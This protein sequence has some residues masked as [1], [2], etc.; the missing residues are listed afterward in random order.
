MRVPII[1]ALIVAILSISIDAYIFFDIRKNF[2][3]K[4]WTYILY[5][6]LSA[7]CW[8][9]IAICLLLPRRSIN[10]G[11]HFAMWGMYS[12]LT[13]YTPKLIFSIFSILGQ[14]P[15]LWRRKP[16]KFGLYAG[17]PLAILTFVMMWYGVAVTRHQIE[18][19]NIEIVSDRLPQGFNG[20]RIV[21]ISD[22]HTG[23]WGQ[24]TR[25]IENLA[26]TVNSLKPDIVFFTGDIVNRE[27]R[28]LAPFMKALSSIRAPHGVYSILGNHDYGDYVS[29]DSPQEK[30]DNLRLLK[31][32]ERQIGW[33]MLNNS[34]DRIINGRDTIELIGVENWGEPPFHQYG[35][36]TDAYPIH[37]DSTFNLNDDRFK[38]LLT[39]N[40][41]HWR[42]EVTKI[43]NI[44]LTLSGH[45][46]AM[47]IE[48]R[49]GNFKW[50]PSGWF[51]PQ[52]SGLYNDKSPDG[53]KMQIY[54]NIGAGEV[55][56]PFRIGAV[57]E[58]TVLTL[59]RDTKTK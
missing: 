49:L 51:Y 9:F 37:N 35:H 3:K 58:V 44:D 47:Q 25:F 41:E 54:V 55:G 31:N 36:L 56:M 16:I 34:R 40:P 48:L 38:I 12:Y 24:N 7:A 46:H 4:K 39:H 14:I 19:V 33:K 59:Q 20:F 10:T 29:W 18:V 28:E 1:M 13:V 23:T 6:A 52:W 8:I 32:W 5:A 27:T 22:L 57:P 53:R 15:R 45:T 21:Q 43:S 2:R 11:I 26:D 50:S 17:L 42:R 30:Q